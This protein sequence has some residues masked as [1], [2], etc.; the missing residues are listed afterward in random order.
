MKKVIYSIALLIFAA[1]FALAQYE[2]KGKV[3]KAESALNSGDLDEAKAEV[4]LAF[5]VD[6]KGKVTSKEKNWYV[7]GQ[8]YKNIFL[9]SG[10][11]KSL[12]DNALGKAV[13]SY[14]KVME[15]EENENGVYTV[16]SENDLNQLYGTVI[17]AGADA[18]NNSNY[19]DAYEA[20]DLA[21]EVYPSDTTA[22]LY[23]G[24]AAQQAEMYDKAVEAY[25]QL[26]ETGNAN[27]DIYKA[28]V[29]IY[30]NLEKDEDAALGILDKAIKKFPEDDIFSQ[31]KITLL[32]TSKRSEEAKEELRKQ[33][34]QNPDNALLQYQLGYLYD[35]LDQNDKALDAYKQ[36]IKIDSG[37]YDALFNAGAIYYNRGV[38]IIKELN[39]LS[40]KEYNKQEAEFN[41]K[42]KAEFKKALP[43]FEKAYE[44]N[45][46]ELP[47]IETLAGV[48]IRMGMNE[49]AKPLEEKIQA[50]TGEEQMDSL[51]VNDEG[52]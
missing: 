7:R 33:I 38:D 8:V 34:E 16:Y 36:A 3:N 13:E 52:E 26:V 47:L 27:K 4:D 46:D 41:K 30:R 17:N 44:V 20:F 6:K 10:K 24:T 39:N 22:L 11:Y 37:Y 18:Y 35:E 51:K 2:P 29:Y 45:P 1:N 15:M 50:M 48:Y 5:E 42:W 40:V 9:D 32:I 19:K 31:E 43:Y 23:A 12:D 28:L 25:E 49:K 21:L 14:N